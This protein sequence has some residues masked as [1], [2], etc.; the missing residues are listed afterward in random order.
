MSG[1]DYRFRHFL[2]FSSR[3]EEGMIIWKDKNYFD[4]K[5]VR[6]NFDFLPLDNLSLSLNTSYS[7]IDAIM[8]PSDNHIYGLMYNTLVAYSPVSYTHLTLPTKA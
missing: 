8:P 5:T 2:S 3:K 7:R 4:R 6:A 1:G